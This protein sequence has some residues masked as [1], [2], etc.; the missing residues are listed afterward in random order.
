[1]LSR[2]PLPTL[3]G[4]LICTL[5]TALLP[6]LAANLS[7]SH[8]P[9]ANVQAQLARHAEIPSA[10]QEAFAHQHDDGSVE[11]GRLGHQHGHSA[12]DHTHESLF[13]PPEHTLI[14]CVETLQWSLRSG[15]S[16][17]SAHV[18]ALERPPKPT[19]A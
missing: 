9:T 7:V 12:I 10:D 3:I 4:L 17:T 16:G 2:P 19:T 8:N 5:I 13:V 15:G 18:D 11:E 1:M 14:L 6:F